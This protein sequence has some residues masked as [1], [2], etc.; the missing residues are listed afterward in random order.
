MRFVRALA[1]TAALACAG[2][3][4]QAQAAKIF[5]I[6]G[7]ITPDDQQYGAWWGSLP[8]PAANSPFTQG[9]YISFSRPFFGSLYVFPH[10]AYGYID[11]DGQ[12]MS[13]N[14]LF[15]TY[16]YINSQR[17]ITYRYR[18]PVLNLGLTRTDHFLS[19]DAQIDTNEMAEPV[20]FTINGFAAVPEPTTWTLMI[21]GLC[22][23]GAAMRRRVRSQFSAPR[24]CRGLA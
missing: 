21:L 19:A 13:G 12:W 7:T 24:V 4:G 1:A 2:L 5:T 16:V 23:I 9:L 22:G 17:S 3:S 20:S 10:G 11:A 18:S 15:D 14:D 8:F 6:S